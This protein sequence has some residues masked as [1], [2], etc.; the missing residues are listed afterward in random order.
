MYWYEWCS[1]FN[2]RKGNM[3]PD[4]YV[5]QLL[6]AKDPG[7]ASIYGFSP[8]DAKLIKD[9]GSSSGLGRFSVY[10]D[11]LYMDF[12]TGLEAATIASA[13][14]TDMGIAHSLWDSGSKGGHIHVKQ[15][16]AYCQHL[17]YCQ[18]RWVMLQGFECDLS[19]YQHGRILSLPGRI[20][21]KTGKP[22]VLIAE[23]AGEP[24]NLDLTP[25]PIMTFSYD[26][27]GDLEQAFLQLAGLVSDPPTPGNRH[28]RLW[29]C[30]ERLAFLG[31]NE[32]TVLDILIGVNSE[33][34]TPK[35][36]PE[37]QAAV[38]QGFRKISKTTVDPGV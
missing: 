35:S 23:E 36:E 29:S 20:H 19:L 10:A 38:T 4:K 9:S 25:P 33:W 26:F 14:L 34:E 2:H 31:F 6:K 27:G 28:Q 8:E 24:I 17:P 3:M 32:A 5:K 22:K 37:I 11:T 12:D 30:A 15:V 18:K 16:P 21:P 13:Q 1:K 7:Y